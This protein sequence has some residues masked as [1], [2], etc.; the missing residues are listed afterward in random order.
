M[1]DYDLNK[2]LNRIEKLARERAKQDTCLLCGKKTSSFCNS[3]SIPRYIL[4]NIS[5]Q[6]F[7]NDLNLIL[8]M[9]NKNKNIGIN[10]AGV[11][12][13]ICSDCDQKWFREYEESGQ[14]LNEILS[15]KLLAEIALKMLHK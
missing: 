6:G 9:P 12:Y 7:V 11:F 13:N 5:K 10:K 1:D 15:D 3:H 8:D 2:E 4:N 14:L